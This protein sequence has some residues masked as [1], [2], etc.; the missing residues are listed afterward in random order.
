MKIDRD[1][2]A[3]ILAEQNLRRAK[4]KYHADAEHIAEKIRRQRPAY[5][6]GGGLLAGVIVGRLPVIRLTQ[7]LLSTFSLGASLARTPIGTMIIGALASK[8]NG[9]NDAPTQE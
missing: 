2:A 6:I 1:K 7:T 3:I 8:R 9:D 4:A 5:L